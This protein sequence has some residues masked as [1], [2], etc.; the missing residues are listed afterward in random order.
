MRKQ[1]CESPCTLWRSSGPAWAQCLALKSKFSHYRAKLGIMKTFCQRGI[2]F[3]TRTPRII[4]LPEQTEGILTRS[5][6]RPYRLWCL[7][8]SFGSRCSDIRTY[9]TSMPSN[10]SSLKYY[11]RPLG[12]LY[13][14]CVVI[15]GLHRYRSWRIMRLH[16]RN[17]KSTARPGSSKP[18]VQ[19]RDTSRIIFNQVVTQRQITTSGDQ[20]TCCPHD[21]TVRK[22]LRVL[23]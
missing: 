9:T 6:S 20:T 15:T 17:P 22:V 10:G 12:T 5:N 1:L 16:W 19:R 3:W 11:R 8:T 7:Q 23:L 13:D 18:R 21:H 14:R 2:V 4:S